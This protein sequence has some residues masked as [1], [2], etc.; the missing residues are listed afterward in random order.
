MYLSFVEDVDTSLAPNTLLIN[1][2]SC[3]ASRCYN[4]NAPPQQREKSRDS[5]AV[6][7]FRGP[8]GAKKPYVST[9][10]SLRHTSRMLLCH[11]VGF[12]FLMPFMF[13]SIWS[14][15]RFWSWPN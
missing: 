12:L 5:F 11:R 3:Y 6:L 1:M 2:F 7:F 8:E 9:A 14:N 4:N 13:R 15:I 10:I